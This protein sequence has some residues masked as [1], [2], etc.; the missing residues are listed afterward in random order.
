MVAPT[1]GPL[2]GAWQQT[3]VTREHALVGHFIYAMTA[4]T[5]VLDFLAQPALAQPGTICARPM[6]S[7]G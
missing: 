5:A 2:A 3:R 1:D 7:P 6:A 4:V